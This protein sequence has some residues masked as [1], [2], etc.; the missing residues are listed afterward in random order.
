MGAQQEDQNLKA[1]VDLDEVL[2]ESTPSQFASRNLKDFFTRNDFNLQNRKQVAESKTSAFHK[3]F[4]N[5]IK[6][7]YN[8]R[9]YVQALAQDGSHIIQFLDLSNEMNLEADTVYV[10]L[11]LFYNKIKACELID[12]T[13]LLQLLERMPTLLER[14]FTIEETSQYAFDLAFIKKN[15]ENQLL[16]KFTDHITEFDN[17]PDTFLATLAEELA[18]YYQQEID[19]IKKQ[20]QQDEI[21]ERLR[22]T[23]IKFFET[24]LSKCIWAPQVYESIWKSFLGIA[25]GLQ[26]LGTH[27]IINHMDDLDDLFWSLV[28]R[29]AFF[30]DLTGSSLPVS[31]YE[32]AEHDI[33]NN[34]V[35]FLEYKEQDEGITSKKETLAEAFLQAKARAIAY[36]KKGIISMPLQYTH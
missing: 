33:H 13:V 28:H 24:A 19:Q 6:E 22:H 30:L 5:Y 3:S 1:I 26:L 2:D 9:N 32:E 4:I 14:Y 29:F 20:Q 8:K 35:F 16:I 36:E 31:F 11:R 17:A 15:L 21:R 25:N 34:A 10:C 12:D 7:V 18:K 27:G 23:V